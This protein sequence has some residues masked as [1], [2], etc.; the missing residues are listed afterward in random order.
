MSHLLLNA[1]TGTGASSSVKVSQ[2][3]SEHS[4][5]VTITGSPDAVVVALQG[6]LDDTTFVTLASHTLTAAE[7][8]AAAAI[9]HVV[10]KPVR[11]VRANL[12]TLTNGTDPT[13]TVKYEP[14]LLDK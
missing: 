6:S 2:I 12:T 7:L 14:V 1:A 9:F 13:V 11:Y 8:S 3:P 4:V 10:D 5:Q